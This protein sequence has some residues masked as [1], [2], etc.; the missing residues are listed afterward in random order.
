MECI[1]PEPIYNV[2]EDGH[3]GPNCGSLGRWDESRAIQSKSAL[4]ALFRAASPPRA[5]LDKT[6][7]TT[8][9]YPWILGHKLSV[10]GTSRISLNPY[11][12]APFPGNVLPYL[13]QLYFLV[14]RAIVPTFFLNRG[15]NLDQCYLAHPL[16]ETWTSR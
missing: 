6:P 11:R 4:Q 12:L 8:N 3:L 1:S 7:R 5:V 2:L 9:H 14:G 13:S 15:T 10:Q 16:S